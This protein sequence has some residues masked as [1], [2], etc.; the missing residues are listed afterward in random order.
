M[1]AEGLTLQFNP[2]SPLYSNFCLL[3]SCANI[4]AKHATKST[5]SP[6]ATPYNPLNLI[7]GSTASKYPHSHARRR[8]D[9]QHDELADDHELERDQDIPRSAAAQYA[10]SLGHQQ[11]HFGRPVQNHGHNGGDYDMDADVD[12]DGSGSGDADADADP[13]ADI[14]DAVDATMKVED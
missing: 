9:A 13:D 14:M 6:R 2:L 7:T 1:A 5:T 3:E 4:I 12:A 8:D 10:R 11:Q